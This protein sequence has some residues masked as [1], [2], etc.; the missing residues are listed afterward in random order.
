LA[1]YLVRK[2]VRKEKFRDMLCLYGDMKWTDFEEKL[3]N[4]YQAELAGLTGTDRDNRLS[5]NVNVPYADPY[6]KGYKGAKGKDGAGGK[7]AG[8]QSQ[9][10]RARFYCKHQWSEQVA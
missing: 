5:V 1:T 2:G 3:R 9:G 4:L 7:D 8:G 10:S 6:K